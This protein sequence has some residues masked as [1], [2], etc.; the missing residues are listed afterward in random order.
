MNGP[1]VSS[2]TR[3]TSKFTERPRNQL[4]EVPANQG[5]NVHEGFASSKYFF[6]RFPAFNDQHFDDNICYEVTRSADWTMCYVQ[7]E[8][9]MHF[10]PPQSFF[11]GKNKPNGQIG[12]PGF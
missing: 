1:T 4:L 11:D 10:C 9:N 2:A 8:F 6:I 7:H 12:I 3:K 5:K